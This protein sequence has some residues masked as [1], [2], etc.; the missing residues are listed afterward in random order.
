MTFLDETVRMRHKGEWTAVKAVLAWAGH[1]GTLAAVLLLAFNDHLG[2]RVWP[3][4]VTGKLSDLAWMLVAPPILALTVTPVLRLRGDWPALV[5]LTG[6]AVAFTLTKASPAGA[7][8]TSRIWSSSGIPSRIKGDPTDLV[9]LPLLALSW[10]LWTRARRP[11]SLRPLLVAIGVPLAAAA[12]VATSQSEATPPPYDLSTVGNQPVL[13]W[14]GVSWTTRDGGASWIW[15]DPSPVVGGGGLAPS[16]DTSARCAPGDPQRCYRPAG[17]RAPVE[18]SE[19]G[20]ASWAPDASTIP[21]FSSHTVPD[22]PVRLVVTAVPAGY[23]VIVDF[24]RNGLVVRDVKGTWARQTYPVHSP[25]LPRSWGAGL[26]IALVA[27]WTCV[28]AGTGL[29]RLRQW[30][31]D[32]G[33]TAKQGWRGA[34]GR[35]P[36][37]GWLANG[38]QYESEYE[39]Q[40]KS[41]YESLRHRVAARQLLSL[42]WLVLMSLMCSANSLWALPAGFLT[43]WI[44]PVLTYCWQAPRQSLRL[45]LALAAVAAAT[46]ALAI[47]PFLLWSRFQLQSW[48]VACL[49]AIAC[50]GL[51]S[52]ASL[53]LASRHREAAEQVDLTAIQLPL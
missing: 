28:F 32:N 49:L 14:A 48:G 4:L 43:L 34:G 30:R 5:A 24:P 26:P 44:L 7:E 11:R 13:F 33:W 31:A 18:V 10:W 52:L 6:T 8:V 17:L 35:G 23:T 19:D 45:R 3:G 22:E 46:T 47:E 29:L 12:M 53:A 9:A 25:P 40:Y 36:E 38:S 21:R 39:S 51:G 1:P 41:Q 27:G 42:G 20:G 2:K 37:A 16:H 50:S 15:Q